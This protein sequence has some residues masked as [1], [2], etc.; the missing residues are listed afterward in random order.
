MFPKT[1]QRSIE[2]MRDYLNA[3]IEYDRSLHDYA[4]RGDTAN[5]FELPGMRLTAE[6]LQSLTALLQ[7]LSS[8]LIVWAVVC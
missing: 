3:P 5:M 6:E 4:Y 1:V 2:Q 7:L 8:C